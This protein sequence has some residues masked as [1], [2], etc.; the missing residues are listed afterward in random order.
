MKLDSYHRQ[1]SSSSSFFFRFPVVSLVGD[2]V[3]VGFTSFFGVTFSCLM[4]VGGFLTGEEES[5]FVGVDEDGL[6]SDV[7]SFFTTGI[8]EFDFFSA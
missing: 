5:F 4:F 1:T 8:V 3:T 2:E 6:T 7:F